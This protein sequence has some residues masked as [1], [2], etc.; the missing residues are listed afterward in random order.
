MSS[1]PPPF[2]SPMRPV[3]PPAKKIRAG[4]DDN[5]EEAKLARRRELDKL[6]Q[7]GQQRK[8]FLAKAS[9]KQLAGPPPVPSGVYT[10]RPGATSASASSSRSLPGPPMGQPVT[11]ARQSDI[12]PSV[13]NKSEPSSNQWYL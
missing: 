9:A 5:G 13:S 3:A 12:F 6:K 4:V 2:A 8:G 7:A 1:G 10:A 11:R